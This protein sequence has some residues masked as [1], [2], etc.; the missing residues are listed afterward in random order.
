MGRQIAILLSLEDEVELLEV[1]HEKD[2]MLTTGWLHERGLLAQELGKIPPDDEASN[3][4][5]DCYLIPR[6]LARTKR[7]KLANSKLARPYRID[8][9]DVPSIE[10]TRTSYRRQPRFRYE[11]GFRTRLY[12]ATQWDYGADASWMQQV[13]DLYDLMVKRIKKLTVKVQDGWPRY[14]S[15]RFGPDFFDVPGLQRTGSS[16]VMRQQPPRSA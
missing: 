5:Y 15:R 10:W 11:S 16:W 4:D 13:V 8:E 6:V 9:T 12:I 1:A 3:Y 7:A 2:F 14:V